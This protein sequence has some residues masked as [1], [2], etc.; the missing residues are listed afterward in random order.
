MITDRDLVAVEQAADLVGAAHRAQAELARFDQE[1]ID[2]ICEAMVRAAL[3]EARRLGTMAVEETGYG[4]AADKDRK[5]RSAA[6]G[7]W[8]RYRDLRTVGVLSESEGV[9]EIAT[10]RG[11]VAGF[12]PSTEPTSAAIFKALISVK[13]RN[14]LVLSPHHTATSC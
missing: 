5:N 8:N 2:R 3:Y 10:P 6:E 7:T 14:A 13:S 9:V 1:K 12:T 11:V 4:V